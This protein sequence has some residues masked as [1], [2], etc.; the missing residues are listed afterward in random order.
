MRKFIFAF[1]LLIFC[2]ISYGQS[3][4]SIITKESLQKTVYVLSHDSLEGRFTG[5]LGQ[6]KAADYIANYFENNGV[7]YINNIINYRDTFY[8]LHNSK[9][10][11]TLNIIGI[12]PSINQT[13]TCVLISAHYDHIGK[14]YTDLGYGR[15][16]K[17]DKIFNGANDNATGIAAALEIAKY[18]AITKN[19]K[20]NLIFVAFGAEELGLLGSNF[21]AKNCNLSLFKAV[22][23]LEM[24]GRPINP[25]MAMITSLKNDKI[26]TQLNQSLINQ[27][28]NSFRFFEDI[29]PNQKLVQRSDHA[30]FMNE[31]ENTFT[32]I[33]TSP[34]DK[35]YHT[36]DDEYETIDF[37][38][39]TKAT[40]QIA[41][42]IK[43]FI[44]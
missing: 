6:Y 38:Y 19:N 40:K 16:S 43:C 11:Q 5:K 42:A 39:L 27:K 29:Y 10:L 28:N 15:I 17:N 20:Y 30:S 23:N 32:I 8:S 37:E 31:V 3:I 26:V 4:D 34:N 1:I 7:K 13:D 44:E 9:K 35:F 36:V 24:L 12:L 25:S 2:N 21:F 22:I 14:G 18:Y 33:G 41:N